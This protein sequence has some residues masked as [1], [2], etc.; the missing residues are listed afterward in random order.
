MDVIWIG[1]AFIAFALA[2]IGA[3]YPIVPSG[4]MYILSIVFFGLYIGFG[5][6]GI[7]FWI[8]Q[9]LIVILLFVVDFL[10]S[11]F[12]IT[13]IGGS[14]AAVWGSVIGLVI[15]P[16][17]IPVLGIIIGAIAGA[18]IGELIAGGRTVKSLAK[19]GVGSLLGFLAGVVCKF[20]LLFIGLLMIGFSWW[21]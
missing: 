18:I 12:G 21:F 3:V 9:L 4:P 13:R 6:F 20:I 5:T 1:L 15:G 19:I 2:I 10:T 8:G 11:Y 17:I 7:G 14:K 16:F